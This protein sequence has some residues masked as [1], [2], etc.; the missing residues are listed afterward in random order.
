MN[1]YHI[2]TSHGVDGRRPE[3]LYIRKIHCNTFIYTR[4]W[5]VIWLRH[6]DLAGFPL[7]GEIHLQPDRT[8]HGGSDFHE[9]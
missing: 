4:G 2:I 9:L 1:Y 6:P 3:G 7:T 8:W 5:M